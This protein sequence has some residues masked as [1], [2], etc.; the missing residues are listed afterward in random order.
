MEVS[1]HG[2]VVRSMEE[3]LPRLPT[4]TLPFRELNE[5]QINVS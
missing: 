2:E 5:S 4:I 3:V 1:V